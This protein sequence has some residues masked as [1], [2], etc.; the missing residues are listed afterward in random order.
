VGAARASG[1]LIWRL[2]REAEGGDYK[3]ADITARP[4]FYVDFTIVRAPVDYETVL[5]ADGDRVG[6]AEGTL[7]AEGNSIPIRIPVDPELADT[8]GDTAALRAVT[9][10]DDRTGR[11]S[12]SSRPSFPYSS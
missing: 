4:D 2:E 11:S 7:Q 3:I 12:D 1:T 10:F 6:E 9:E 8:L 5:F